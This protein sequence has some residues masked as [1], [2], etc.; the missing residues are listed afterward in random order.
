MKP[1]KTCPPPQTLEDEWLLQKL[2]A[3]AQKSQHQRSRRFLFLG[4]NEKIKGLF[5]SYIYSD[6]FNLHNY[7]KR[8]PRLDLYNNAF[9][10]LDFGFAS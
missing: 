3:H 10:R 4:F 2:V 1:Q 8:S 9:V 6:P 7:V 5:E